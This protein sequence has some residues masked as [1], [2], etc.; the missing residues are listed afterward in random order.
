VSIEAMALGRPVIASSGSGFDEIIEDGVS[1]FLVEPGNVE[2][3]SA[4]MIRCVSGEEDLGEIS[5]R[6]EKR[7]WDFDVSKIAVQLV[8]YYETVFRKRSQQN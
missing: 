8:N 2:E 5:R 1:G 3:L 4:Q 6:A 7:S